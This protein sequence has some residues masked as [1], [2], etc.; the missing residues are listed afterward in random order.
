VYSLELMGVDALIF[1]GCVIGRALLLTGLGPALGLV[2]PGFDKLAVATS[3]GLSQTWLN[4]EIASGL[5]FGLE[6]CQHVFRSDEFFV[7]VVQ[8]LMS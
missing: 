2:N 3:P 1:S 4:A 7:V 5:D 8:A 6:L